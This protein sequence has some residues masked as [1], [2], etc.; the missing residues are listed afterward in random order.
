[1]HP[2]G[3]GAGRARPQCAL[4]LHQGLRVLRRPVPAAAAPVA[5]TRVRACRMPR[6]LCGR[7]RVCVGVILHLV[8]GKVP[9]PYSVTGAED[10]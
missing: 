2:R 6:G 5:H 8:S 1:M 4:S 3:G 7:A 10:G 9:S